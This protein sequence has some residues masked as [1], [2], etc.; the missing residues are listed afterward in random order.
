[1][2]P[3]RIHRLVYRGKS[4]KILP[5]KISS[6]LEAINIKDSRPGLENAIEETL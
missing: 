4:L 6:P 5:A 2:E 3:R 1:M